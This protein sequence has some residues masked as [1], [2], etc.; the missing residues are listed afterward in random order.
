MTIYTCPTPDGGTKT[1][2]TDGG[3]CQEGCSASE[4]NNTTTS[5]NGGCVIDR[6]I[7]RALGELVLDLGY[8]DE[9]GAELARNTEI[10]R[11]SASERRPRQPFLKLTETLRT[12]LAS[13]I[14][15]SILRLGATYPTALNFRADVFDKT[16]RGTE[17]VNYYEC[18]LD[19]IYYI[20]RNNYA[21]VHDL[22]SAWIEV[23]PFVAAMLAVATSPDGGSRAARRHRLS[24]RSCRHAQ[25]LVRRFAEAAVSDGFRQLTR[26]LGAE[27]AGYRG[28]DAEQALAK[29]RASPARSGAWVTA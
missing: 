5:K 28:L 14:M 19:E 13:R 23:R 7:T 2:V 17:I 1:T 16:A 20:A 9:I 12:R 27:V 24:E 11:E 21:L 15:R 26:E 4:R 10:P 18:F 29:L 25:N 6:I 22:A 3:T 8:C